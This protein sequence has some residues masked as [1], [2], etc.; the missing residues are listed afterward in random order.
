MEPRRLL[1]QGATDVEKTLLHSA[2]MDG[3]PDGVAQQMLAALQGL[4]GQG[5][6]N[7]LPRSGAPAAAGTMKA[8]ATAWWARIGRIGRIGLLSMGGL[9]ALGVGALVSSIGGER[10]HPIPA[11]VAPAAH[12]EPV[13]EVAEIPPAWQWPAFP[14]LGAPPATIPLPQ[15]GP[16]S[17]PRRPSPS[18]E[19]LSAEI[20]V[21]DLARA[22][23][24]AHDLAAA[25]HALDSYRRRFPQG[26]LE[27]EAT[28]L[29]LAVLVQQGKRTAAQSL[30]V[31]LLTSESYKAYESRIRSLL[32]DV[33]A[34]R[35][36]N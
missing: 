14:S 8:A 7:A 24:D 35:A 28:V 1:E 4:A 12:D 5:P 9:G 23:M 27:P 19:S 26:R 20:R 30:A 32:R 17:S 33:D 3:P 15:S 11:S 13:A 10:S 31:Q 29:R 25:Q 16:G 21:L 22:A 18:A 2:C 34:D 36:G 6:S